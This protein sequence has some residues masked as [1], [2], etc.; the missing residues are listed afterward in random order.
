MQLWLADPLQLPVILPVCLQHAELT[1]RPTQHVPLQHLSL[2]PSHECR[3]PMNSAEFS[4][5]RSIFQ[6][7]LEQLAVVKQAISEG[8]KLQFTASPP[9]SKGLSMADLLL[10][11]ELRLS[12]VDGTVIFEHHPM[13]VILSL[14]CSRAMPSSLRK[15]LGCRGMGTAD[16]LVHCCRALSA[17]R[18]DLSSA[19]QQHV[20]QPRLF[21]TMTSRIIVKGYRMQHEGS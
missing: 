5:L 19:N 21:R 9:I 3:H 7:V 14:N 17:L 20:Q 2:L 13:E 12:G 10:P 11:A 18:P 8:R 15:A 1:H 16:L 4:F 6:V